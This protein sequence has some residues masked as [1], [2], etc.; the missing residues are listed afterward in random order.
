MGKGFDRVKQR[1]W[2]D[3]L[4]RQKQ[5]G[6]SIRGFCQRESLSEAGF[7]WWRRELGRRSAAGTVRNQRSARRIT[8]RR[9]DTS[10]RFLPITVTPSSGSPGSAGPAYEVV[11]P[12]GARV[13]VHSSAGEKLAEVL[14]AL[15]GRPC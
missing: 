2:R 9:H 14:A 5:S 10:A 6:L 12:S 7:H 11:L 15:E 4:R 8:R 13:L 1:Q 3:I